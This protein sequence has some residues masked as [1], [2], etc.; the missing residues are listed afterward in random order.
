MVTILFEGFFRI[1]GI[2]SVI[3]FYYSFEI[4]RPIFYPSILYNYTIDIYEDIALQKNYLMNNPLFQNRKEY[5]KFF[6]SNYE[7][8]QTQVDFSIV[9]AT[10][11]RTQCLQRIFNHLIKNRPNSTEIIIS[12]D[13]SESK[14]KKFLFKRN[15]RKI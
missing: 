14:E 7:F 1:L 13:A 9:I 12:D 8:S 10:H 11:E 2:L 3:P 15:I 4:S 5:V 6:Q